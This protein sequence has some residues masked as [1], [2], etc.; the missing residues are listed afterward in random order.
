MNISLSVRLPASGSTL[1]ARMIRLTGTR[2]GKPMSRLTK[3]TFGL[4]AGVTLTL[5]AWAPSAGAGGNYLNRKGGWTDNF[6]LSCYGGMRVDQGGT[7]HMI[8]NE[9]GQG[10]TFIYDIH[11]PAIGTDG[12]RFIFHI[13]ATEKFSDLGQFYREHQVYITPGPG[14]NQILFEVGT[15]AGTSAVTKCVGQPS[16]TP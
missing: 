16:T 15:P 12:T 2:Q 5:A 13:H 11:G 3:A 4:V 6:N 14:T 10:L 1:H 7:A 8:F 9:T